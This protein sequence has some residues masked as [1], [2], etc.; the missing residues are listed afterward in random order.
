M[1][2]NLYLI[3]LKT[4]INSAGRPRVVGTGTA[5]GLACSVFTV[6]EGDD[7]DRQQRTAKQ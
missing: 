1:E 5:M 7:H 3:D 2:R 6:C 4:K